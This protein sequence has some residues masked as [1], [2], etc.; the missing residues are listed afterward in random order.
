MAK[1][2]AEIAAEIEQLKQQ[3]ADG[4]PYENSHAY[5][6]ARFDW[7]LNGKRDGLDAYQRSVDQA[8][9]NKLQRE[10]TAAEGAANR[11]N[12]MAIAQIGKEQ[13]AAERKAKEDEI[14]SLK[15]AQ[16]RP[17]YLEYQKKMLE[18]VDN[19]SLDEAAIYK[20][21]ME[22]LEAE[23]GTKFGGDAQAMIDARVAAKAEKDK[24]AKEESKRKLNVANFTA[25]IPTTFKT[26]KAKTEWYNK[27]I[28][29]K[30]M[31][32]EE[33]ADEITRIRNIKSG[34]TKKSESAENAV[35]GYVGDKTKEAL[36]EKDR[37]MGGMEQILKK[38]RTNRALTP[39]QKKDYETAKK[40]GWI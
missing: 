33:K 10:A 31:T 32:D 36:E 28:N 11:A 22:A 19:G 23:H 7:L 3:M 1:S 38:I 27:V 15:A 21:D 2:S 17:N 9:Q 14:K 16:A 6:A 8:M 39:Q 24:K 26:E 30:D 18:A 13:A 12:A 29:N 37:I 20:A 34:K 25:Q 5:R 35:A 40:N 4:I